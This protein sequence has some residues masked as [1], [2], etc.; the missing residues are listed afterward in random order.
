M[1]LYL[2]VDRVLHARAEPLD[3]SLAAVVQHLKVLKECG[4]IRTEKV[5]RVCTCRLDRPPCP[6]SS[7]GSMT[8]AHSGNAASIDSATSCPQM[9]PRFWPRSS[10]SADTGAV[11]NR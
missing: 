5:G 2:E 3:I 7:D 9:T 10:V 4:V 6:W 1:P 8:A 11:L